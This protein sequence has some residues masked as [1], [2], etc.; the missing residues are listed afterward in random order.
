MSKT[1]KEHFKHLLLKEEIDYQKKIATVYHL[2]GK[3]SRYDTIGQAKMSKRPRHID[4]EFESRFK[5]KPQTRANKIL[6]RAG[7]SKAKEALAKFK[8]KPG[9]AYH[10]AQMIT[11]D[12][13]SLGSDFAVG[14]GAM[15]G[16]GLYT[17][18]ELNPSVAM[19]YGDIILRFDVDIS[20]F[21]IF[22]MQIAK[23]I[24][25]KNHSLQDQMIAILSRKGINIENISSEPEFYRL[26]G[27]LDNLNYADQLSSI[28]YSAR[29]DKQRT[30]HV[31][32]ET[33]MNFSRNFDNGNILKLRD[34]VDGI[35]FYGSND[36]P[37]CVI[38]QPEKSDKYQ[39]TGAGYFDDDG[40]PYI[41]SDINSLMGSKGVDLKD[42]FEF[43]LNKKQDQDFD[44]ERTNLLLNTLSNTR[45]TG[46]LN[47]NELQK[48]VKQID[49]IINSTFTPFI[50]DP[51]F[52]E[53]TMKERF[54]RTPEVN[55]SITEFIDFL[56]VINHY[57]SIILEPIIEFIEAYASTSIEI[58]S[59][60]DY[61]DYAEII[62][63]SIKEKRNPT[64]ADFH[65]EY[66]NKNLL[67]TAKNQEELDQISAQ[68]FNSIKQK[69]R[70]I[71]R[72]KIP[73][74][75][76][77]AICAMDGWES[78]MFFSQEQ[79]ELNTSG[80]KE[81]MARDFKTHLDDISSQITTLLQETQTTSPQIY[82]TIKDE[83]SKLPNWDSNNNTLDI[84]ELTRDL[85]GYSCDLNFAITALYAFNQIDLFTNNNEET[86]KIE[87][88]KITDSIEYLYTPGLIERISGYSATQNTN[89]NRKIKYTPNAS[90]T[91]YDK[92]SQELILQHFI[93]E[94]SINLSYALETTIQDEILLSNHINPN[95][96]ILI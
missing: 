1:L 78:N 53:E 3:K 39:L 15:Y 66:Q 11:S 5:D 10:A 56:E 57:P 91:P 6:Q 64:L 7:S 85:M 24:Y 52:F 76:I 83:I 9:K 38:Y 37:V 58:I 30:A 87:H 20:N 13:Y 62:K 48:V 46:D 70:K 80:D 4:Q 41:T 42:T 14:D 73:Q 67:L 86:K 51:K 40:K 35:I 94:K 19:T 81:A 77:E 90:Q 8:T 88:H 68:H 60:E 22:N 34:I 72:N 63:K 49:D 29:N 65:S 26:E 54:Q 18:Y 79:I 95:E 28:E 12:P 84:E 16:R 17:C 71:K 59:D 23:Q 55:D 69:V 27:F 96:Q 36:G 92:P 2:T 93:K 44:E 45:S 82:N 43:N 25:G 31:A 61:I 74:K 32:L 33:V 50:G 47:L 75:L 89:E 21:L